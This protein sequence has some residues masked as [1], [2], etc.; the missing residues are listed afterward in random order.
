M[1]AKE[2]LSNY[3]DRLD[4]QRERMLKVIENLSEQQFNKRPDAKTWSCAEVVDHLIVSG[5]SYLD[6]LPSV[7]AAAEIDNDEWLKHTFMGGMICKMAGPNGNAPVPKGMEPRSS[8]FDL[9]IIEE[10]KLLH[11]AQKQLAESA[12]GKNI[13]GARFPNPMLKWVKMN[14]FD[15]L[16][17]YVQHTERHLQQIEARAKA[18]LS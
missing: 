8:K 15:A 16:E 9:K 1:T 6:F 10:W 17:I 7:V 14:V 4:A 3:G 13:V 18:V 2:Y 11:D 12:K 5:G